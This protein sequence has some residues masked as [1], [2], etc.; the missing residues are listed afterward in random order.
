MRTGLVLDVADGTLFAKDR[1]GNLVELWVAIMLR[2]ATEQPVEPTVELP[3]VK[4]VN[5]LG[6]S[7]AARVIE[8]DYIASRRPRNSDSRPLC[9][10]GSN[11]EEHMQGAGAKVD[12]R[13][14][15][16]AQPQLPH[17]LSR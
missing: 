9:A 8:R 7:S 17:P 12:A 13:R 15:Q 14:V 4:P 6:R 11:Q 16:G 1:D 10:A 2:D 5:K 3:P